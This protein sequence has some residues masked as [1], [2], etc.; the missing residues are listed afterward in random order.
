M[1][2]T[3]LIKP[4]WIILLLFL[5][6]AQGFFPRGRWYYRHSYRGSITPMKLSISLSEDDVK[7]LE[8]YARAQGLSSRS[9]VVQKAISVLK[10]S[11]LG[12]AYDQ[13]WQE[14]RDEDAWETASG[15][16]LGH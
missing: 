7:F 9:A 5:P 10:S 12:P 3:V 15:D 2:G 8:T 14:W 16:G 11:A 4:A 13:A 1:S 6:G